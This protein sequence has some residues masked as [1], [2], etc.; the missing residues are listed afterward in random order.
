MNLDFLDVLSQPTTKVRGQEGTRG[1]TSVHEGRGVPPTVPLSGTMRDKPA[2]TNANTGIC[3]TV[4]P[5]RPAPQE[6]SKALHPAAV[7]FVP[8]CPAQEERVLIFPWLRDRCARSWRAWGSEK[9]LWDDYCA[10]CEQQMQRACRRELFCETMNESFCRDGTGWQ[11]V[12]LRGDFAA[13]KY[14]M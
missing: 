6:A 1:T 14:V 11:G 12:C 2:A 10:W 8:V 3:P 5:S 13:S 4:S 9:S 7:P